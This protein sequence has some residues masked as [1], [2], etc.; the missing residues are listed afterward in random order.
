MVENLCK[1]GKEIIATLTPEKA[2]LWHMATGVGNELFELEQAD[3]NADRNNTLEELGDLEFFMEGLR[4]ATGVER[5]DVL[6]GNYWNQFIDVT[7]V[8]KKHV[9]YNKELDVSA[10]MAGLNQ[11]E[12]MM[13][14][15]RCDYKLSREETLQHC[16]TKL[17]DRYSSGGYTDKQAQDRADKN[18]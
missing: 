14:T 8:V 16:I 17:N 6:T 7:D 12:H 15:I 13:K 3:L 11:I 2:H 5:D 18:Q 10:L 1:D 4:A 9:V